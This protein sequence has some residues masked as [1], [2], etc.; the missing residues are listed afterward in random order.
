MFLVC[1]EVFVGRFSVFW[2]LR[3]LRIPGG[4]GAGD[5]A[6]GGARGEVYQNPKIL[7]KNRNLRNLMCCNI[8]SVASTCCAQEPQAFYAHRL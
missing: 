4:G 3:T 1:S 6:A 5:R 7:T 8:L 2:G